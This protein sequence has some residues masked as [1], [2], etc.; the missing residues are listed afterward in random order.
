MQFIT[1]D[2][3]PLFRR[4]IQDTLSQHFENASISQVGSVT[5]LLALLKTGIKPDLLCLDLHLPGANGLIGLAVISETYPKLPIL[6]VS[7]HDDKNVVHKA[8]TLGATGFLPKSSTK[9]AMVSAIKALLQGDR[10]VA[11]DMQE[12]LFCESDNETKARIASLTSKQLT[13]LTMVGEGL[14]NKEIASKLEVA[15]ATVRAHLT[16]IFKK[17]NVNNRTQAVIFFNRLQVEDPYAD[18]I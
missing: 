18:D 17:L 8:L 15:D 5:E 9:E 4:G 13:V 3:H 1:A 16:E 2:D 6:M 10:W 11:T 12:Q 14:Y 7:G